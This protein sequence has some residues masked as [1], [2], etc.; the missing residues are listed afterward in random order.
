MTRDRHRVNASPHETLLASQHLDAELN[1]LDYY[2]RQILTLKNDL[3]PVCR[4]PPE[5]LVTILSHVAPLMDFRNDVE[6]PFL[7]VYP[8]AERKEE[9]QD[10]I[11]L[12]SAS[13]VC[14]Y[15]RNVALDCASL[16]ANIWVENTLWTQEMLKRVRGVPLELSGPSED[17]HAFQSICSLLSSSSPYRRLSI[18]I[19]KTYSIEDL[20]SRPAPTLEVA[21]IQ[22]KSKA[23]G[24][25]PSQI[26]SQNAPHLRHLRLEGKLEY[27]EILR[28]PIMH[29][30]IHLELRSPDEELVPNHS[31]L[32]EIISQMP[33]LKNL[34]LFDVLPAESLQSLVSNPPSS[35]DIV[36]LPNISNL[37]LRGFSESCAN[38]AQRIRV[39]PQCHFEFETD[40]HVDEYEGLSPS[41]TVIP[42][43]SAIP[44]I[45]SP[46]IRALLMDV[47]SPGIS[48]PFVALWNLSLPAKVIHTDMSRIRDLTQKAMRAIIKY[49]DWD[50]S[51]NL[52]KWEELNH[53]IVTTICEQLHLDQLQ[54]LVI[55]YQSTTLIFRL[56]FWIQFLRNMPHLERLVLHGSPSFPILALVAS[57]SCFT[58]GLI[59][60]GSLEE[61]DVSF[62]TNGSSGL[63]ELPLLLPHLSSLC[64]RYW[65][66]RPDTPFPNCFMDCI[67]AISSRTVIDRQYALQELILVDCEVTTAQVIALREMGIAESVTWDGKTTTSILPQNYVGEV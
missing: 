52:A 59:S 66:F 8:P 33:Q 49:V 39:H 4:L 18:C 20:L 62:D 19:P 12:I 46:P 53:D 9:V 55:K 41:A 13:Q 3:V 27:H 34:C 50:G 44:S 60:A 40:H 45:S 47:G 65:R 63:V 23:Y 43:L 14:R 5:I 25:F 26:F 36:R 42:L 67:Y 35:S 58:S 31:E 64:L 51:T 15:W 38:F 54:D 48:D 11:S 30:L 28:S 10:I 37:V 16:W 22:V 17:P 21:V 2:R 56:A 1:N 32:L 6:L 61:E 57:S 29:N 7:T 24:R